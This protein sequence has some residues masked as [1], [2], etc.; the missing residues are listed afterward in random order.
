MRPRITQTDDQKRA[1][2]QAESPVFFVDAD[3]KATHVILPLEDARRMFDDY[4]RRGLQ[5]GF[6]QADQGQIVDWNPEK[7]KAEGR[8]KLQQQSQAS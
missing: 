4:L 3:G 2:E 7:I 6:D 1:L 8:R 5:I